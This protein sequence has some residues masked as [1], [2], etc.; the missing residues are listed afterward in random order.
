SDDLSRGIADDAF[1]RNQPDFVQTSRPGTF[2]AAGIE[3]LCETLASRA[4][5]T[6][7]PADDVTSSTTKLVE[8][9]MGLPANHSRHAA[10]LA[11]LSSHVADVVAAG[12]TPGQAM[13]SAFVVACTS[14]DVSGA[15]L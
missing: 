14:P 11:A 3:R 1:A 2:H 5:N 6:L 4:V 12:G 13:Q 15:G 8:Q 7:F 10:A 9:F